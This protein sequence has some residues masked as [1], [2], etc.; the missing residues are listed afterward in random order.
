MQFSKIINQQEVKQQLVE[1]VQHNRLSH[2]LLFLSK[3]GSGALSLA[4][5]LAQYITCERINTRSANQQAGPSLFEEA[6]KTNDQQQTTG[7][8]SCGICPSCLK[9]IQL[10]HPDIH[11]SYPV[12]TKKAGTPPLSV[13][14]ITEWREFIKLYPY[15]NVY[16]WLQFIGAENKQGNITA[17]ECNDIIRKLSLKSFESEYKILL[18]WMPEYLGAEGNKL[19]KLVE[20]PPPNTLFILV[21]ENESLLLPTIV[22]R[23]QMIKIPALDTSDIEKALIERSNTDAAK[24]RQVAATAEGNYR[25]ALQLLQHSEEDWQSLLRDWLNSIIKTGP[26]AQTKW[27]EEISRLGRE[28]Q[29]QFL[30]YFNHLLEQSIRSKVMGN[31]I[32]L[33]DNE[34]DFADRLNRLADIG[35]QQAL[36]EELDRATYYIERNANAKILFHALTIKVY[37]IIQ[38]KIVF[39]AT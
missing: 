34:K 16:D 26:I 33:P 6:P 25:E 13:D 8:D 19:L 23:C 1:L 39:L 4:L 3:E 12:V 14:Y 11:F 18:M 36:I 28:K 20:E 35:Q 30:R 22:S 17:N 15:G 2:A 38:D 24:A 5:A 9:A 7:N 29:K 37:H 27:V 21:A 31:N 32:Y 10:I